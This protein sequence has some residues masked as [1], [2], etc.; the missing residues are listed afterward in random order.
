LAWKK[1]LAMARK[2]SASYNE[3]PLLSFFSPIPRNLSYIVDGGYREERRR[4]KGHQN[5][6]FWLFG[7][8]H[9]DCD[10]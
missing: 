2:K 8:Y 6:S 4:E 10:R 3:R 9:I 7:N 5:G 1:I